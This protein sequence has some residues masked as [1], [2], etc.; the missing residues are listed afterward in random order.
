M[1]EPTNE[2]QK[3][4][5]HQRET[6]RQWIDEAK[7]TQ[8]TLAKEAGVNRMTLYSLLKDDGKTKPTVCTLI[9]LNQAMQ[10]L[11]AAALDVVD[12][13]YDNGLMLGGWNY[14]LDIQILQENNDELT[15]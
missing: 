2:L 8:R 7:V 10:R 14:S 1:S 5:Q 4:L 6:I 3:Y 15:R 9:K 13:M 11:D 12:Y